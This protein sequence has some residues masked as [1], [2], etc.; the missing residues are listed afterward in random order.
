MCSGSGEVCVID[1]GFMGRFNEAYR[2]LA[3][4]GERVLGLAH[5]TIPGHQVGAQ[6]L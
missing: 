5:K 3:S 4:L 1:E 6:T 2:S